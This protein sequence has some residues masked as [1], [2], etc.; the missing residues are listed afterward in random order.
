MGLAVQTP[1]RPTLHAVLNPRCTNKTTDRQTHPES[2]NRGRGGRVRREIK[3][4]S[5]RVVV[6][7]A[8]FRTRSTVRS[9]WYLAHAQGPRCP[10]GTCVEPRPG[11]GRKAMATARLPLDTC[12]ISSL[13]PYDVTSP[14]NYCNS[15]HVCSPHPF[16][17]LF[18]CLLA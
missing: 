3:T 4:R 2:K 1:Q 7:F 17:D 11:G 6:P 9:R 10:V 5:R 15:M 14:S 8:Q 12:S 16:C 18:H 13:V